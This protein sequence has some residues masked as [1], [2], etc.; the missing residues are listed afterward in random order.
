VTASER[1]APRRTAARVDR[2][3]IAGLALLALLVLHARLRLFILDPTNVGWMW[4]S[5]WPNYLHGLSFYRWD[6]WR[7]PI[8]AFSNLL[9]PVGTAIGLTDSIPPLAVIAKLFDPWLPTRFQYF[10]AYLLVCFFLQGLFGFRIMLLLS[11]DRLHAMLSAAFLM[12]A[13]V[14]LHRVN[15]IALCSHWMILAL[16][17]W[18]LSSVRSPGSTRA[19]CRK[20]TALN[21]LAAVTHPYL[22]AMTVALS[23]PLFARSRSGVGV[24]AAARSFALWTLLQI[25]LAG[26]GWWLFGYLGV[27]S[28]KSSGFGYYG[29][30]VLGFFN[31]GTNTAL[32]PRILR[33]LPQSEGFDFIGLG[34]ALLVPVLALTAA[35]RW[36]TTRRTPSMLAGPWVPRSPLFPLLLVATALWLFSLVRGA[37]LFDWLGPI[38]G[39][40]RA[41][42]RFSWPLYYCITLFLLWRYRRAFPSRAASLVLALLLA[43]Q[44]YD[45]TPYWMR[46]AEGRPIPQAGGDPFWHTVGRD[47]RHLV[48][49]PQGSDGPC[50]TRDRVGREQV[51]VFLFLA[52]E[53]RMTINVGTMSRAPYERINR[54][55]AATQRG[56]DEDRPEPDTLYVLQP[57]VLSSQALAALRRF[58]CHPI[59]GFVVCAAAPFDPLHARRGHRPAAPGERSDDEPEQHR[60][61][62]RL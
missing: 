55:C 43:L 18:N 57:D 54:M 10:G 14:L 5:D 8:G 41:H 47:F 26:A 6:A 31:P 61:G 36:I 30:Q 45:L 11:G 4:D 60:G 27:E 48:L 42:G 44:V 38:P 24:A 32:T 3:C 28:V 33:A 53:Q 20:A 16:L 59:D 22:W 2:L 21:L 46:P 1:P 56:L 35:A 39:T 9:H 51:Q 34:I 37:P 12:V 49:W 62:D 13:P 25:A 17:L 29:G 15:H 7:F 50:G 52:H 23:L 58:A 19:C 40:F